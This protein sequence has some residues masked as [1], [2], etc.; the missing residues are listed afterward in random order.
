MKTRLAYLIILIVSIP[1]LSPAQTGTWTWMKGDSTIDSPG[2]FGPMGV[3][4]ATNE[5]PARYSP[6]SWT[7]TAGI[8]WLYGGYD[9][10]NNGQLGDFWKYDPTT[11][12]WT[13]MA[14]AAGL[15]DV[16]T[17]GPRGTFNSSNNPGALAYFPL[18]WVDKKNHLWIYGGINNSDA[19]DD[20]WQY[21]PAINQWAW[22][23]GGQGATSIAPVYGTMGV[24]LASNWPGSRVET[25]STWVDT[26]GN[27]WLFGGVQNRF[28][29]S[30]WNDMWKYDIST[31][32]WTWMSGSNVAG[33]AGIYGPQGV[34]SVNYYPTG[35]CVSMRWTDANGNFYLAGGFD[36]TSYWT[37]VWMFNPQNLKWIWQSGSSASGLAAT[38]ST[39]CQSSTG[40]TLGGR[41]ENSVSW[42]LNDT[43]VMTYGGFTQTFGGAMKDDVWAYNP[44]TYTWTLVTN[45]ANTAGRYGQQGVPAP[46]NYPA[47][48]FAGIGFA[49]KNNNVWLFSGRIMPLGY[50][51]NSY[52]DLW[53]YTQGCFTIVQQPL[54][55][56]AGIS[57][58]APS[59]AGPCSGSAS[60]TAAN[61]TPPYTYLWQPGNLTTDT[62]SNLCAGTY[63]VVITDAASTSVTDSV[64]IV[65]GSSPQVN[66]YPDSIYCFGQLSIVQVSATNGVP[67]Y[68]GIGVFLA[69]PGTHY[70]TVTDS[71]GCSSTAS[72]SITGPSQLLI[73]SAAPVIPCGGTTS[74]IT[75][76]AT[77]GSPPYTGTGSFIR[78][79]GTY[80]DSVTD[81][82]GCKA[83]DTVLI[84]TPTGLTVGISASPVL[85]YGDTATVTVSATGGINPYSGTGTYYEPAGTWYYS[86]S[87]SA[88]CSSTDSVVIP[89]PGPLQALIAADTPVICS[90][91]SA[92]ICAGAGYSS[93]QW[94]NG[95]T[96]QCI[97]AKQAGNYYV[98]LIDNNNCSAISNHVSIAVHSLPPVSISVNGD[99]LIV[100]NGL[101]PQWYFNN[102]P[103]TGA[104][105]SIY[106]ASANGNYQVQVSDSFGC[107]SLSNKVQVLTGIE[108]ISADNVLIYPN[109]LSIGN[110]QL[111]VSNNLIGAE[112]EIF[113]AEGR[114]VF[115][116]EIKNQHSEIELNAAR[117]VYL[118]RI[119]APGG[120]VVK[121][122][123]KL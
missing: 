36:W 28:T 81:N 44:Q 47:E 120:S 19:V 107:V 72:I 20:L 106:I 100:N 27:L 42:K 9:E 97:Y 5:P 101:N 51:G 85:C 30:C 111:E 104:N 70:Y 8:F 115:K 113:D 79:P 59:C 63:T 40:Y 31:G 98:T 15:N 33:N 39:F 99:T 58:S 24:P 18:T 13:W 80:V 53:K 89:Q 91:D 75:I 95:A 117:G 10:L 74:T 88:G 55:L 6:A 93:Y 109:P 112:L 103:I 64:T 11:N 118:L 25:Q 83:K 56:Q 38:N 14:G 3:P 7:D 4:A 119:A 57:S 116:S 62:I 61:G 123:V 21:D 102:N 87:D 16:P 94:N 105:S 43:L 69:N 110:W 65:T 108:T 41:H 78:P 22:M 73:N 67:P 34:A 1:V 86:V 49:D 50:Q 84:A 23:G 68:T 17:Y 29:T 122:L 71:N 82:N 114:V 121:K 54:P 96:T 26:A 66:I 90:S 35:R 76:T 46:N 12:M 32:I 45:S 52:N 48:R 92:H 2:T 37:D 60:V 77:G